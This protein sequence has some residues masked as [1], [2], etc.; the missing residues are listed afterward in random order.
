MKFRCVDVQ[1]LE[2][3]HV[4]TQALEAP[5]VDVQEMSPD[6]ATNVTHRGVTRPVK[7][8]RV[9]RQVTAKRAKRK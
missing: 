4:E 8:K 1:A 3:P 2:T 5:S 6:P 7:P 9:T